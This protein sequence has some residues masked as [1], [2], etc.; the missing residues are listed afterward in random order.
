MPLQRGCHLTGGVS[1]LAATEA[2][3]ATKLTGE[4]WVVGKRW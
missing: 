1:Y 3:A 4:G 2:R